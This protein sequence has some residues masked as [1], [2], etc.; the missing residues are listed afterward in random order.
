MS[1]PS[2]CV[3]KNT[4]IICHLVVVLRGLCCI[5]FDQGHYHESLQLHGR[6]HDILVKV[7]LKSED[8]AMGTVDSDMMEWVVVTKIVILFCAVCFNM[9]RCYMNLSNFDAAEEALSQSLSIGTAI[10]PRRHHLISLSETTV[11]D[12]CCEELSCLALSV[13]EQHLHVMWQLKF[14]QW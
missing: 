14:G 13:A 10:Y 4:G 11:L 5:T 12:S 9:G 6:L 3:L 7:S 1:S 2:F 8:M